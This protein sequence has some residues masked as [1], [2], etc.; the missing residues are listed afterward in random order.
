[1]FHLRIIQRLITALDPRHLCSFTANTQLYTIGTA[2]ASRAMN[3]SVLI[4]MRCLQAMGSSAVLSVG[5]GSLADMY[6]VK[7][8]GRKLGL[9]YGMPMMG[10]AVGPLIGGALGNVSTEQSC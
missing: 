7:E 5:A 9:Y 1:M 4:G 6:E 3:M 2:V 10:P 8:R